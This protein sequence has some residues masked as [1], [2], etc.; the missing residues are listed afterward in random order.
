MRNREL[1]AGQADKA[2][3]CGASKSG[4]LCIFFLLVMPWPSHYLKHLIDLN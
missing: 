2:A 1:G 4:T 3:P